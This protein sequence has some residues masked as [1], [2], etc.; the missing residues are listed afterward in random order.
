MTLSGKTS[1]LLITFRKRDIKLPNIVN[2][3]GRK[4]TY[5]MDIENVI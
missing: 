2:M 4:F 3:V 5:R 1:Y